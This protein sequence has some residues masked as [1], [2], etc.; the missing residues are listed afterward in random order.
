MRKLTPRYKIGLLLSP[1]VGKL[2]KRNIAGTERIF[3]DDVEF[4]RKCGF[5]MSVCARFNLS[6]SKI[7]K[8]RYP[9]FLLKISESLNKANLQILRFF[10]DFLYF[11]AD[12]F[13]VMDFFVRTRK[14]DVFVGYSIPL[15]AIIKPQ[16]SIIIMEFMENLRMPSLFKKRYCESRILFASQNLRKQFFKVN[17]LIKYGNTGILYN[18]VDTQLFKPSSQ[19]KKHNKIRL[20]FASAW[21][22]EKGLN[23]LLDALLNLSSNIREKFHLTIASNSRLWYQEFPERNKKYLGDIYSK[24]SRLGDIVELLGGVNHTDMPR[25]YNSHDFLLFPSL[26]EEPF[27][28]VALE[29]IACG[30]PVIA[31]KSGGIP[32]I[33]GE[34]NSY[35]LKEKTPDAL[36]KLLTKLSVD[37]LSLNK[38]NYPLFTDKN[39]KMVLSFRYKHLLEE[40]SRLS[41]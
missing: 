1:R 29:A 41:S 20:L 19:Q 22:R 35:V 40:V 27:G 8:T 30:L 39:M 10:S 32:E 11:L 4:F 16:K 23:V 18:A 3:L 6:K 31:F 36:S 21:I 9:L 14:C 13:Y 2:D 25:I 24:I 33:L 37:K 26:W 38:K 7:K 17:P 28:L 12:L 15:M 34:N 5:D